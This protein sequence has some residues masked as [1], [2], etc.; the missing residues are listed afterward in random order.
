MMFFL[1][2]SIT[3]I[4]LIEIQDVIVFIIHIQ[5]IISNKTNLQEFVSRSKS[6]PLCSARQMH[7]LIKII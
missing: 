6:C 2:E 3:T 4:R 5:W 7:I 1:W